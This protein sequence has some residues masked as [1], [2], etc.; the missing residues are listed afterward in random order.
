ME[1]I[2]ICCIIFLFFLLFTSYNIGDFIFRICKIE[3]NKWIKILVGYLAI[4]MM[5]QI[6]YYP[7]QW[8]QLSSIYLIF[9]GSIFFLLCLLFDITHFKNLK[10][11]FWNKTIWIIFFIAF[12]LFFFYMRTLPHAYWFFDDSFYLPYMYENAHADRLL[13]IEARSGF[14]VLKVN[15]LYSY[16]GYYFMGSFYI[17]LFDFLG[18]IFSFSFHYLTVVQYFMSVPTFVFLLM[19]IH[20]MADI[21]AKTKKEKYLY[22]GLSIFY[23]VF[24]P[25]S[26]N[27]L[28]NVY[29]N[30]YIGIFALGTIFIPIVVYFIL[31][32][33]RGK[34][35]FMLPILISFFAMLSYASF[36]MF[37]IFIS[38]FAMATYQVIKKQKLMIWDYL[39][40]AIPLVVYLVSFIFH[41]HTFMIIPTLIF[42]SIIYGIYY[43]IFLKDKKINQI[44]YQIIVWCI[45]AVPVIFV[46]GSFG[47]SIFRLNQTS[48]I[49]YVSRVISIFFPI[50]G[51]TEFYYFFLPITLFYVFTV[52]LIFYLPRKEKYA[53]LSVW[54]MIVIMGVFLNPLTIG[55][56]TTCLT[57]DVYERIFL[58][59]LNPVIFFGIYQKFI[60]KHFPYPKLVTVGIILLI[61]VPPILLLKDFHYWVDVS[62]R[63]DKEVRLSEREING[64]KV[65][66]RYM[67]TYGID[68]SRLATVSM[69]EYRVYNPNIEMVFTRLYEL[70]ADEN[71]KLHDFQLDTLYHFLTGKVTNYEIV[72]YGTIMDAVIN[73]Q[74]SFVILDL[75]DSAKYM[76]DPVYEKQY[77]LLTSQCEKIYETGGYEVYFTGVTGKDFV[78]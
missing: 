3:L 65:I 61:A 73:N 68:R 29:M 30:G 66:E 35:E 23:S 49:D 62:G 11:V 32:Y 52:F 40:M 46:I 78:S 71:T 63:S 24:L 54:W 12:L 57:S 36:S 42:I 38:L 4:V 26:A 17:L 28:N 64:A 18:S 39:L 1:I 16:Q 13:S 34:R 33:L 31:S 15:N 43:K 48:V 19:G 58:L 70:K 9:S 37:L 72:S 10:E 21:M 77:H 67:K 8:F 55:F 44:V 27:I 56:V 59:F 50:Y 14:D 7:A 74:I 47:I 6:I 41:T 22:Y 25:Y 20:G 75:K 2:A 51:N 69:N 76:I 5:F 45:K 53:G 60:S